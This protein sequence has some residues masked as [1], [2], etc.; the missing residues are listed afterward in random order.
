MGDTKIILLSMVKNETRIIERLMGSVKGKVDAIVI[1]DT[2]ST[3]DTVVKATTWLATNDMSGA[4]FEFP[5]VNFGKSRTE[6]FLCCQRWVAEVGWDA[7]KTWALLLDGDMMLSDPIEK[8]K[9]TNL[10]VIQAGVSLKQ[11]AGSLIYSNVRLLRCSEPWICKGATHEAWTC[12]PHRHTTLLENPV[13]IDH[14]DGGCKADKYSRDVR[15]LKE[16][17]VEMP[18]DARTHFYLGQTYLCMRD[19]PNAI[20]T[21]KRRIEIGGWDEEVYIARHYLGECYENNGQIPDAIYTLMEAWQ[22]RPFRTEA[23]M[24]AIRIYRRQPKSQRLAMMLFEKLF[25]AV[26]GEDFMSGA[27]VAAPLQNNDH[28]FVNRRD[29]EYDMWEELAILGFYTDAGKQTWLRLDELDLTH[30][31][32]WHE[33]NTIFGHLHWYDWCLKPRRH[34]RFQIPVDRLPWSIEP[35]SGCWQPFNPSIRV[36]PDG[37]GY[38][39]NLR[40]A[41][42]YTA[43][44]KHYYYRAFEGRVLTRNCLMD[45]AREAGWNNPLKV[46]EIR[47]D[48]NIPQHDH[49]IRGVEDCRLIQGTNEFEFLGTSQSYSDN[50]TNKIF[51]VR[52]AKEDSTWTLSQMPL[53]AGVGPTETQKNWLGFRNARGE[54]N[55]IYNF[56]PYRVC[57]ASGS[58]VMVINTTKGPLCLREYRGSAGPVPWKSS[59]VADEAYICVM[60][61]VYIGGAGRRYYHRFMTLDGEYRPS[62]VS[63]FVRFSKERVEYWSGMCPSLEGDSYWITYGTRD[64]EAYIA[65]M[66]FKEVEPLLMYNM[67]TGTI[68]PTV[69]RLKTLSNS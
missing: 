15:L 56:S 33:F 46:E 5:F 4:T 64:S 40:Y 9:L 1:C 10:D 48:P 35:E 14:G 37:S 23:L 50:K 61:K 7:A 38:L 57:N 49:Y 53:P 58:D 69:E 39:V 3:D 47:M 32:N 51:H 62:R 52:R 36:K 55:Y 18:D 68:Q 67:K 17:L 2:G 28:L 54:L 19:W 22:A 24:R 34:T 45:V 31:L 60:H 43:E 8:A 65:E 59:T 11:S 29:V 26:K 44:A 25:L 63:C 16:D 21:L 13:L 30:S 6:S 41:N 42:Y 20:A 27:K 12:P 66:L